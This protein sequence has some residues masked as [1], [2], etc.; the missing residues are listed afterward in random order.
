MNVKS[1]ECVDCELFT[2]HHHLVNEKEKT[3]SILNQNEKE[4]E[5][6]HHL[7]GVEQFQK[8]IHVIKDLG[9]LDEN[10]LPTSK[11][12]LAR[13]LMAGNEILLLCEIIFNNIFADL[14]TEEI[15]AF[16]SA[17]DL[18]Q[19]NPSMLMHTTS[20]EDL[21]MISP[22]LKNQLK[23]LEGILGKIKTIEGKYGLEFGLFMNKN[24]VECIYEWSCGREFREIT[25]YTDSLEGAIVRKILKV[26]RMM[27]SIE[28][29][30]DMIKDPSIR[31]KFLQAHSLIRRDVVFSSSLYVD[32]V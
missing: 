12:S 28:E 23:N 5:T 13:K 11:L 29:N 4:V 16:L 30:L 7:F 15:P 8:M 25:Q 10:F 18:E 1:S 19:L 21:E 20:D 3:Q 14:Q 22:N 24:F 2:K 6:L 26:D 31:N 9:Y 17:V 27:T 32:L